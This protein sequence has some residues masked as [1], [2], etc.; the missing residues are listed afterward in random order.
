MAFWSYFTFMCVLYLSQLIPAIFGLTI[1][2]KI[3][4]LFRQ[5]PKYRV[6]RGDILK[7]AGQIEGEQTSKMYQQ[8]MH[9]LDK[10]LVDINRAFACFILVMVARL[11]FYTLQRVWNFN[12]NSYKV[13]AGVAIAQY[14]TETIIIIGI[15][16]LICNA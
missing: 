5:G 6:F 12:Q 15:L 13:L 14:M 11:V 10:K 3:K 8:F 9:E 16:V 1:Y 2:F 7:K 4:K